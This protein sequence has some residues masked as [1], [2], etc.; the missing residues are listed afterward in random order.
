MDYHQLFSAI[1][2][3]EAEYIRFWEDI[4]NLES[5]TSYK[6]G[7]DAVADFCARQA[8]KYGWQVEIHHEEVSG[9]A[10]CITMNPDAPG[11]AVCF[12]GHMDTVHPVGSFGSP[13]VRKDETHIYGPGVTDCKGGVVASFLAMAA[14]Q[15]CGFSSRPVKLILQSDEENSSATS[16]KGTVNFMAEKAKNCAVFLNAE[17]HTPGT[18][19]LWRKGIGKYRFTITGKAAHAS[20]CAKKGAS[21]IREAAFKIMQIEEYKDHDGITMNCGTI[22]GGTAINVVPEQCE[23]T[24]DV[25]Y[26]TTAQLDEAHNFLTRLAATSFVEGCTSQLTQL[27]VRPAMDKE[28][29]NF[30]MLEQMNAVYAAAGLPILIAKGAN[31]GSDAADL[32]VRG[33]TC[34]DSVGVEGEFIHSIRE[35]AEI[36]SLARC[37]K[38]LAAV[39]MGL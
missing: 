11:K 27:S 33:I 2:S 35:Q 1:D 25:R 30:A 22:Q 13:A 7:V 10:V 26:A 3:L 12:S 24:V 19:A 5:P 15:Q 23:F 21:A 6:P 4:C 39:A 37:A 8:E 29:R 31:G 9:N 28:D 16:N 20:F 17:G 18:A 14:L 36:A 38:R 32:T 34:V